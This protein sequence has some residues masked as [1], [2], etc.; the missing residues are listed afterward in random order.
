[1]AS[2][3]QAA[4]PRRGCAR[5][6]GDVMAGLLTAG[7]SGVR[8]CMPGMVMPVVVEGLSRPFG[9]RGTLPCLSKEK[10][11]KETT[12]GCCAAFD[13]SRRVVGVFRQHLP[14]LAK[15]TTASL[16]SS[17]RAF[18]P[19]AAATHGR[20]DQEIPPSGVRAPTPVSGRRE[21]RERRGIRLLLSG[22]DDRQTGA[23]KRGKRASASVA[24]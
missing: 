7:R 1:H 16:R 4:R 19:P 13:G 14:V 18:R 12:P 22:Q 21:Q 2:V 15:N 8:F 17:L 23:L 5:D 6:E 10:Y 11:P 3:P 24:V 20:R 9:P